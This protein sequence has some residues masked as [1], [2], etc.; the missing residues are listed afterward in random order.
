KSL[1]GAKN[2][3]KSVNGRFVRIELPGKQRTLTLAEVEVYSD[4]KNIARKGKASQK[5]TAHGGVASRAIDGNKSGIYSD[6]GAPHTEE[7]TEN[8]WWEVDLGAEYPIDSIQIYNRTEGFLRHR[9]QGFTLKVLDAKRQVAFD[10]KDQPAPE[11]KAAIAVG[12]DAPER[13][14]RRA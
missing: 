6:G 9:L 11:L 1:S 13:V 2:V 14:V 8:P 10:K 5:N 12:G 4:G 3:G 7:D